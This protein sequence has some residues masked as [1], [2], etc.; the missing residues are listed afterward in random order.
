M[1]VAYEKGWLSTSDRSSVNE[2]QQLLIMRRLSVLLVLSKVQII[3]GTF[4]ESSF[5]LFTFE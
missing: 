1:L 5:F 3:L 4:S 2:E